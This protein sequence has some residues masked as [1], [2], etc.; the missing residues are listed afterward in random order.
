VKVRFWYLETAQLG[1]ELDLEQ[2]V[3]ADIKLHLPQRTMW[4]G[5]KVDPNLPLLEQGS[6][7]VAKQEEEEANG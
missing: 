1:S 3:E 4:R 5:F 7:E 2:L 6:A